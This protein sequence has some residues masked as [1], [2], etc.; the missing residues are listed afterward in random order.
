M[1]VLFCIV[2]D[3]QRVC[4]LY[5]LYLLVIHAAIIGL[6]YTYPFASWSYGVIN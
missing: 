3:N 2:I 1:L 6:A 4:S 5:N